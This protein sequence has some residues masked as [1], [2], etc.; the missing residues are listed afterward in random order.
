MKISDEMI[1]LLKDFVNLM[2]KINKG[3]ELDGY[4]S[5]LLNILEEYDFV[6]DNK[7]L[8]LSRGC[9]YER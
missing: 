7:D 5:M 2:I 8:Y 1:N 4:D 9:D 3:V 6:L